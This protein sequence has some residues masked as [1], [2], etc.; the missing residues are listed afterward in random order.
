MY[1]FFTE[2][3][4]KKVVEVNDSG[5]VSRLA[6]IL[7]LVVYVFYMIIWGRDAKPIWTKSAFWDIEPI[8]KDEARDIK[9]KQ[10]STERFRQLFK[11]LR[12]VRYFIEFLV[13]WDLV[14]TIYNIKSV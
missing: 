10:L 8:C 11:Y 1:T 4:T 2:T 9:V 12:W 7:P 13:G 6:G 14:L 3:R 5:F